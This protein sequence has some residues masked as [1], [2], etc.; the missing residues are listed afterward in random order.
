[1]SFWK[2]L[3]GSTTVW[4][5]ETRLVPDIYLAWVTFCELA[6]RTASTNTWIVY[7]WKTGLTAGTSTPAT[8][9]FPFTPDQWK[10]YETSNPAGLFVRASAASQVIHWEIKYV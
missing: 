5:T 4:T 1:M 9:G 10:I 7:V 3:H 2:F 6:V 8:D